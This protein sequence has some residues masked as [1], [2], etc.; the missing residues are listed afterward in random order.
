MSGPSDQKTTASGWS[1]R[2]LA[3]R[4]VV[5]VI[6]G[7]GMDHAS[8]FLNLISTV[9]GLSHGHDYAKRKASRVFDCTIFQ[10]HYI[11]FFCK[12]KRR[13]SSITLMLGVLARIMSCLTAPSVCAVIVYSTAVNTN[14]VII[15]F[16]KYTPS[17]P[18]YKRFWFSRY[19]ARRKGYLCV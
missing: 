5:V 18:N 17:L 12:L 8:L 7:K 4:L 3:G 6:G 2:F 10:R 14:S 13:G 11:V 1:L 19:I 9:F 16:L 15:P